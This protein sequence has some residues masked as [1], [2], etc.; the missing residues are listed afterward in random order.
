MK[1][2]LSLVPVAFT[3]TFV[4]DAR[5]N[6]RPLPFTYQV[7]TLGAGEL[8]LEQIVDAVVVE[9]ADEAGDSYK[10]IRF[11]LT[12]ELEVALSDRWELGF[13]WV[14]AQPA[15]GPFVFD[16]LKQRIRGRFA[17][18]G[19]WPIDV[20]I[21]LEVVEK[22][23]EI[24]F[25]QKI[26][27]GRRFGDLLAALNLS[28]EQE[29]ELAEGDVELVYNPS[30]G[31]SYAVTPAVNLGVEMWMKGEFEGDAGPEIYVGPTVMGMLGDS[32]FT[33]GLYGHVA[34]TTDGGPGETYG[35][36]WARAMVG[37]GL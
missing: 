26:L 37:I 29:I 16:G 1:W 21:Y 32:F 36:F 33:L 13:Y 14:G 30:L 18:E 4:A 12:T 9:V 8:E 7:P 20:G 15:S 17:D 22:H 2:C 27:L 11:Q 19:E 23:D 24:E 10:G 3:A 5:A 34:G 6:P 35:D 28:I 25:E 31:V